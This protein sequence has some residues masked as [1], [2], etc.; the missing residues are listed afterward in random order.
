MDVMNVCLVTANETA[1]IQQLTF[2][3][4]M[5]VW[6]ETRWKVKVNA[7]GW[8][9]SGAQNHRKI[10]IF[11]FIREQWCP[12]RTTSNPIKQ[13]M[14]PK[15]FS[16]TSSP[17]IYKKKHFRARPNTEWGLFAMTNMTFYFYKMIGISRAGGTD[18]LPTYV[19][20][21]R[22]LLS[23]LTDAKSGKAIQ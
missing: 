10:Q 1:N 11:S 2:D 18:E 4:F 19:K 8:L 20:R 13:T 14:R 17:W 5:R 15:S 22:H 6:N 21:N 7:S 12:V 9:Y 23:L 3:A 16:K